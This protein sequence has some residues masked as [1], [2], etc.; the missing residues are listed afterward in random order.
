[1]WPRVASSA[2]TAPPRWRGS[3]RGR[4]ACSISA[5][6][7]RSCPSRAN[8]AETQAPSNWH[9]STRPLTSFA[10]A[11]LQLWSRGPSRSWPLPPRGRPAQPRSAGTPSTWPERLGA[12]E[13]VM[14]FAS[15]TLRTALVTTHA[16]LSEVPRLVTPEAVERATY[17]LVRLLGA[18]GV[19]GSSGPR[20]VIAALNP[21]AGEGRPP[22]SGRDHPHWPRDRARPG[23]P[24]GRRASGAA[25]GARRRGDRLSAAP[26]RHATTASWPCTTI[27]PPS[28]ASSLASERR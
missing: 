9:G 13:V 11:P 10:R 20:V 28:P 7:S 18:L 27:K 1:M 14:A 2:S 15:G 21:H 5:P 17:W 8:P 6:P 23:A 22:R 19:G 24:R 12:R 16:P 3:R 4:L 26:G 25:H